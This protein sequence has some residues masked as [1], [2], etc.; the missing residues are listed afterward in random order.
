MANQIT[1]TRK[2]RGEAIEQLQNQIQSV[3]E[4]FHTAKS[5]SGN[6]EYAVSVV[7][8]EWICECPDNKHHHVK[9]KQV[10]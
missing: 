7:D 10:S 9:C 4:N 5:Q 8:N 6:G 2:E 3:E 1:T